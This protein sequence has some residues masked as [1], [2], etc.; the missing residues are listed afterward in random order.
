MQR[1]WGSL[2]LMMWL[3]A[4]VG[5][6]Q[7]PRPREAGGGPPINLNTATAAQLEALPGIGARTAER[8]VEFRQKNGGFKKVEDLMQVRGVGEKSFLK[9]KPMLTVAAARPERPSQP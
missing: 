3:V 6:Q 8:I 9:L 2:L 7:V 1:V 4:G 5:A